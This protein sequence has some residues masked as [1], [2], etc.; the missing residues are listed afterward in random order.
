MFDS[1]K[2]TS[3]KYTSLNLR[4]RLHTAE[5]LNIF[6]Y[7]ILAEYVLHENTI[8]VILLKNKKHIYLNV[9]LAIS[10]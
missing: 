2:W 1:S 8:Y 6:A 5:E 10:L 4:T 7:K 9:L 3:G